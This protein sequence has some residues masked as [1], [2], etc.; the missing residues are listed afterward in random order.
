MKSENENETIEAKSHDDDDI[1]TLKIPLLFST[2]SSYH[3]PF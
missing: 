3:A 2:M 1:E